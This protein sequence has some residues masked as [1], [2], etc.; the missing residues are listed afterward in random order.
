MVWFVFTAYLIHENIWWHN[1]VKK[2]Q[3]KIKYHPVLASLTKALL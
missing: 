2:A 1:K 3:V